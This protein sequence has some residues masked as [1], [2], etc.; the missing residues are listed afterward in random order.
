MATDVITSQQVGAYYDQLAQYFL[1]T[2]GD[3]IHAGYWLPDAPNAS[4]A[5]AQDNLTDIL[6]S[7]TPVGPGQKVLDVGCGFGEPGMRLAEKTGCDVVGITI[8]Q[9]QMEEANCRAKQRGLEQRAVY[10]C[11]DAMSLP[12]EAESFD[13]VWAFECLFHMPDRA[14]VLRQITRV[15]RPGGRLVLTDSYEKV[16]FTPEDFAL[17]RIGNL[18]NAFFSAEE[19]RAL[20]TTL[21]FKIKELVDITENIGNTYVQVTDATSQKEAEIRAIYGEEFLA[22][23]RATAPGLIALVHDK[24][25]YFWLA[26]EKAG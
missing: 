24:I 15:L 20:L 19:Y 4:L 5:V 21:G 18:I 8:S 11:M 17:I 3:N 2:W 22:Q 7:Q 13:A 10:H 6:I 23:M 1:L 9:V 12:F 25:G 16:P 26:A 14:E